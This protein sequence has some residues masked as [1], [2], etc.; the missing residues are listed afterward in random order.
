MSLLRSSALKG[1]KDALYLIE[2]YNKENVVK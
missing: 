1:D 2:K